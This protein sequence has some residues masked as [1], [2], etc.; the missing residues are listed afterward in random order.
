MIKSAV[1]YCWWV[2]SNSHIGEIHLG[3]AWGKSKGKRG[4]IIFEKRYKQD[5]SQLLSDQS[6]YQNI[7]LMP[8]GSRMKPNR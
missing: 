5:I 4:K 1:N 7:P 6:G 8:S 3:Y 2:Y